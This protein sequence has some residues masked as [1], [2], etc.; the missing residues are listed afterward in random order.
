MWNLISSNRNKE[1]KAWIDEE[2]DVAHIRSSDG[3]GPLFWAYEYGNKKLVRLL[4]KR[5]VDFK[6][7]DSSGHKAKFYKKKKED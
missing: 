7:K 2:P 4:K 6:S 3:K 5:G 1:L